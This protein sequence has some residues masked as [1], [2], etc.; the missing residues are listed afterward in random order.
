MVHTLVPHLGIATRYQAHINSRCACDAGTSRPPITP[1]PRLDGVPVVACLGARHGSIPRPS[2]SS[3]P[4]QGGN[5]FSA[6]AHAPQNARL[7]ATVCDSFPLA[8]DCG[9]WGGAI[10]PRLRPKRGK[11]VVGLS[12]RTG[13]RSPLGTRLGPGSPNLGW[14]SW[15]TRCAQGRR[16]G[17]HLP[18]CH[19]AAA[20]HCLREL[21]TLI[22]A[23][24]ICKTKP[25]QPQNS[26]T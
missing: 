13:V 2:Y 9:P 21:G 19:S 14:A 4:G 11:R 6:A 22:K 26:I 23:Q 12:V 10:A 5:Q 15:A 16:A 25:K 18:R 17:T 24:G 8:P 1:F 7:D 3:S 20:P